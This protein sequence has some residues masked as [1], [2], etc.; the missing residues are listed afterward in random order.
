M[1]FERFVVD[2]IKSRNA[3]VPFEQG[4]GAANEFHGVRVQLPNRIEHRMI[5][6]IE[7]V[8]LELRMTRDVDLP[9]PMV[10]N[11]IQVIVRIEIVILRRDVNVVHVEKNSAVGALRRLR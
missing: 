10:R 8:F 5:V 1:R 7:N 9:D 11:V 4:R 2:F 6:R 3:V